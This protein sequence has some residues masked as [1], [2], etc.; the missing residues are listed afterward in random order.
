MLKILYIEDSEDDYEFFKIAFEGKADVEWEESARFALDS[1]K[2]RRVADYPDL[3]FLD[4][5]LIGISGL[6]FLELL[7][8]EAPYVLA[9]VPIVI[10]TSS[11]YYNDIDMAYLH[12]V[13]SYIRKPLDIDELCDC[14]EVVCQFYG[15]TCILPTK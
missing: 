6:E 8:R 10:F 12:R 5:N 3:I 7:P 1:L 15:Q 13:S 9:K 14:A 4:L 11:A 2:Q